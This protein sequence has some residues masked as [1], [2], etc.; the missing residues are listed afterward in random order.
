MSYRIVERN[1]LSK[2][3]DRTRRLSGDAELVGRRV[4]VKPIKLERARWAQ[5]KLAPD[6]EPSPFYTAPSRPCSKDV[7]VDVDVGKYNIFRACEPA[8]LSFA[9]VSRTQRE[10][11]DTRKSQL[12]TLRS[13]AA[14]RYRCVPFERRPFEKEKK[15]Q[16]NHS[17]RLVKSGI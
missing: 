4:S 7:D 3:H 16:T 1:V 5:C 12:L 14:D 17:W 15:E 2:E 8:W 11:I 6:L 13:S 10:Y 9:P